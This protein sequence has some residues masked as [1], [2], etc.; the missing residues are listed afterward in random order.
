MSGPAFI[1]LG[2]IHAMQERYVSVHTQSKLNSKRNAFIVPP[3][4]RLQ[5]QSGRKT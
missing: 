5:K 1:A 2:A 3:A 4:F